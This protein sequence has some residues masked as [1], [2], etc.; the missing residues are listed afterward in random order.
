LL[1]WGSSRQSLGL[2]HA[3]L[4]GLAK[5]HPF[6]TWDVNRGCPPSFTIASELSLAATGSAI[7]GDE[8]D[9]PDYMAITWRCQEVHERQA[10]EA[11]HIN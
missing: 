2:D 3:E 9:I 6:G 8:R 10:S 4:Q 7:W 5:G 11:A 1:R